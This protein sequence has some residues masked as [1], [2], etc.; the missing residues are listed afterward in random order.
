MGIWIL[1]E[2]FRHYVL[3]LDSIKPANP[4]ARAAE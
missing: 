2:S 3:G 4:R 1:Y